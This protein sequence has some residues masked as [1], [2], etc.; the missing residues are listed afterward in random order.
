MNL[1][2]KCPLGYPFNRSNPDT[3][4]STSG[5]LE[6]APGSA[7]ARGRAAARAQ[8][9]GAGHPEKYRCGK[10]LKTT[11]VPNNRRVRVILVRWYGLLR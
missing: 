4:F 6:A 11:S 10:D 5:S 9:L 3:V 2:H 7:G 1:F 8:P